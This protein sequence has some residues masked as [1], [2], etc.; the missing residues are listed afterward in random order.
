[1]EML[2]HFLFESIE[3]L[4]LISVFFLSQAPCFVHFS[5]DEF[6]AYGCFVRVNGHHVCVFWRVIGA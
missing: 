1:M 5:V 4:L 6:A 2:I 3:R